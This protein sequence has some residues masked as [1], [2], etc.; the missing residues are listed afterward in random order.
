MQHRATWTNRGGTWALP[1][2][3]IDGGETPEQAAVRETWE[4]TGIRGADLEVLDTM[5]TCRVPIDHV[6]RRQNFS[7]DDL[8]Y[9]EPISDV[10][11]AGGDV[12]KALRERPIHHPQHQGYAIFGLGGTYWWAV[13][14]HT[15]KEWTYTTV[16]ARA[17][18][19]LELDPTEESADLEWRPLDRLEELNLMP[20]F[21]ASLPDVKKQLG[22]LI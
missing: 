12:R 4:E 14:D 5:V 15:V 9:L 8:K 3:A 16:L 20:E 13:P 6:E 2:G 18:R 22:K 10:L 1:G 19:A 11:G 17:S 7:E 21:Q